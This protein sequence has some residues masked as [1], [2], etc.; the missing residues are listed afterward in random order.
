MSR[1]CALAIIAVLCTSLFS[2]YP[3]LNSQAQAHKQKADA[4]IMGLGH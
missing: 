1:H 2:S 3:S 4:V